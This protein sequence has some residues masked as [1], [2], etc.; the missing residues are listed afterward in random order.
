MKKIAAT[1][2]SFGFLSLATSALAAGTTKV[3]Q[4]TQPVG[5]G[6]PYGT[7]LDV[8]LRNLLV[9]VFSIAALLVLIML[10]IGAIQ[11]ILS[12]G[13]KEAYGKARERITHALIGLAIL[14]LAF[15]IVN[16]VATIVGF[17]DIFKL[18]IPAL[19]APAQ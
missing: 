8:I 19:D 2:A 14:A 3:I 15:L 16:Q 18:K 17:G 4:I 13:D 6:I 9:L 12:G 10:I 5:T 7:G 11:W 1:I